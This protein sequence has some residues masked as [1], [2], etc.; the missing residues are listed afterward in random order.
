M[1]LNYKHMDLVNL[2]VMIIV[3]AVSGTLAARIMKGDSFGFIINA[4]LG[5]AGAVVGGFIFNFLNVTP[6]AGIVKIISNTFGV[7][8]P[9][10]LVG[11]VVSATL[12]AII[13]LWV[14]R[15]FG[16]KRRRSRR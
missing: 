4:I 9:Q 5:I 15:I 2:A 11:M 12:G 13:I 16:G 7:D 8:L 1:S 14:F 3:G 10:N 6:G